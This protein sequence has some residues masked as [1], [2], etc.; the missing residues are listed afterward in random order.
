[1][2]PTLA[3][4][5][6]SSLKLNLDYV[7][8]YPLQCI[9]DANIMSQMESLLTS[10]YNLVTCPYSAVPQNNYKLNNLVHMDIAG[11]SR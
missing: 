10:I 7:G 6:A 9:N 5:S 4:H 8:V 2:G 3:R 1:M 11:N